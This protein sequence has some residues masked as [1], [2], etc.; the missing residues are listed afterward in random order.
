MPDP[1]HPTPAQV[2]ATRL[3]AGP[4]T[5]I[6]LYGGS[7]SGKTFALMRL[8]IYRALKAASRHCVLRRYFNSVKRSICFDTLP[9]VM[10]LAFPRVPWRLNRSDWYVTLPGGSEIWFGGLDDQERAD[11]ILGN[12][13]ATIYFNEASEIS[14][15]SAQTALSRLAQKTGLRNRAYY[16]A[17]PPSKRHWL[18]AQF[19]EHLNPV[20]REPLPPDLYAAMLM[21]PADNAENLPEGY[22]DQILANLPRR[23]RQRF[24][25]G[26]W[27]D[28]AEGALW[29]RVWIDQHRVH[30]LP[31]GGLRRIVVAV[32]PAVSSS[33]HSDLTGIVVAGMDHAG[34]FYVLE[35]RSLRGTPAEWGSEV[36]AAYRRHKADCVVAEINQGG[37]LVEANI[38][39]QDQRIRVVKVR[40]TR[41]KEI[42]AEPIAGLSER[43][44]I[45]F[46]G[47]H[48][49]LEDELC[50]WN[51]KTDDR[52]PDR[53]DA[54]V[55]GMTELSGGE[56]FETQGG[57]FQGVGV[58]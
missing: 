23:Q 51:P 35:D 9:T 43:G 1:Y 27:S 39:N 2:A 4:A 58:F 19:V 42:R 55:W 32:D 5:H 50:T 45:H 8:V 13:Y 36:A 28:D 47:A 11:K 46:V 56:A 31:E 20:S 21:N 44:L 7:R 37:D 49:D 16:D 34:Q 10:T 17:N 33:E 24:L 38:H 14:Y 25:L 41:G 6:L 26:L 18:H 3:A 30:K 22:I 29:K 53:L 40:A 48:P 54:M 57:V 52:S 15:E 12:E